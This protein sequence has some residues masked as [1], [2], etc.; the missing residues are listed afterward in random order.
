MGVLRWGM[1]RLWRWRMRRRMG[2]RMKLLG[3]MRV[4]SRR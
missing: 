2:R 4:G 3:I 1:M